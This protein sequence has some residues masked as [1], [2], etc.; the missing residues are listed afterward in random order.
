MKIHK[1]P[2][3]ILETTSHFFFKILSWEI[4]LLYFF[5]WN[6]ILFWQR[7]P[8]RV[9]NFRLSFSPNVYLG[10][11][12]LLKV[13]KISAKKVQ[14][15]CVSWHWRLMQNLKKN[16]FVV[17]KVTRIWSIFIRALKSPKNLHFDWFLAWKI[18]NVWSKKVQRSDLA[19]H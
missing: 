5:S 14:R 16:W 2:H 10:R 15:S 18:C 3:V 19:W 13:Y 4:T 9:P 1:I 7:E 8:I 17:S 12:L 6:F 11:L